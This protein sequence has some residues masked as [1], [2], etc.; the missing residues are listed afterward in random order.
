MT[1]TQ[2]SGILD[3]KPAPTMARMRELHIT[4]RITQR[5]S[6][7]LDKY[8]QEMSKQKLISPA[9]EVELALR[10]KQGDEQARQQLIK[11]NLRFAVS[12]AKQY[13]GRGL[14]LE[15]LI[16][17]GNVGLTKAA[18]RFDETRGFKFISYAV[19]WIR[20][21]ILEALAIQGRIVRLPLNQI[22]S[23]NKVNSAFGKLEQELE[24]P[25]NAEELA[26]FMELPNEKVERTLTLNERN[27]SFDKPMREDYASDTL[28]DVTEDKNTPSP[29]A[30]LI[31]DGLRIEIERSLKTLS[32]TQAEIIRL[33]Y[34]LDGYAPH[35]LEDIAQKFDCTRE[36]ARSTKERAIRRLR[37]S[38]ISPRLKAYLG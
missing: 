30:S 17:E 22:A 20:Q 33:Y 16:N 3:S 25:P 7:S 2:T 21:S 1:S 35:S 15:D 6:V 18:S 27:L 14:S 23:L 38:D 13:Q 9:K 28:I 29:F 32:F 11:A 34:G 4:R 24:R 26:V 37:R 10:I 19:W 31:M 36:N 12:V 5:E 8:L